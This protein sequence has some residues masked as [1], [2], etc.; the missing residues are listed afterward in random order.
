[1]KEISN[2]TIIVN[3]QG[4]IEDVGTNEEMDMKYSS[5]KFD[6]EIDATGKSIVPGFVDAHTHPVWSGDRVHE[7]ALKLAGTL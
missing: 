4:V 6:Q 5:A 1:L 3:H 7:F 2:G